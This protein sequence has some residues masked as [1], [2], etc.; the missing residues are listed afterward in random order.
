MAYVCL[1][2]M[3]PTEFYQKFETE[4]PRDGVEIKTGDEFIKPKE[5]ED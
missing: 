5:G 2:E 3:E 4:K 1:G